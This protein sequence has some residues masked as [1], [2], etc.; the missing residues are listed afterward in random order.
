MIL[1][2][3]EHELSKRVMRILHISKYY[4]PFF[5]GVENICKYLVNNM[6]QDNDI[7]VVCFNED[8]DD[9]VDMVDGVKVYRAGVKLTIARQALSLSYF[10]MLR[11][12]LKEL[13]P[14]VIHF[15]WANHIHLC[16]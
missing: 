15:H 1:V 14:D 6:K 8:R 16:W 3:Q 9:R 4:Y 12:A 10:T 7:A 11:K 13:K 5:G 2:N